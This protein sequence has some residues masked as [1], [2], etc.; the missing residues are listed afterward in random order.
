MWG[1]ISADVRE[2][3]QTGKDWKADIGLLFYPLE[4]ESQEPRSDLFLALPLT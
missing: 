2:L 4:E 3:L 1:I